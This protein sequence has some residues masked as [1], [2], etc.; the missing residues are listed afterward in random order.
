V[1]VPLVPVELF[2]HNLVI[3]GGGRSY[4]GISVQ[5]LKSVTKPTIKKEL[6]FI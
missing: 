2:G 3:G 6:L 4:F 5:P 1:F